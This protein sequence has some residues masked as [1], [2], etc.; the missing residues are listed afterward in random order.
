MEKDL[1]VQL[2][3]PDLEHKCLLYYDAADVKPFTFTTES[4]RFSMQI[5]FLIVFLTG[6]G[7]LWRLE[8]YWA[9]LGL[10]IGH[11][12]SAADLNRSASYISV[13]WFLYTYTIVRL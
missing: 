9:Q 6:W 8:Q 12:T 5:D 11:S 3:V 7:P 4:A 13:S 2:N 1:L 10:L